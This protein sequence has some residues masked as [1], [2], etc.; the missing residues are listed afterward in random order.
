MCARE[1]TAGLNMLHRILLA[2]HCTL[3]IAGPGGRVSRLCLWFQDSN[4][5]GVSV[6]GHWNLQLRSL[7]ALA[8][9]AEAAVWS[10]L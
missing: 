7:V 3:N 6:I 5:V 8:K 9:H 2:S 4:Y 1:T 10:V